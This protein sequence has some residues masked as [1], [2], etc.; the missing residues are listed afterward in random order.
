MTVDDELTALTNELFRR[1]GRNLLNF[2][3][4]EGMLKFLVANGQLQG[5]IKALT[6]L[7]NER[8]NSVLRS[9][10]GVL[11]GKFVNEILSDAGDVED[12]LAGSTEAWF[13]FKLSF[14]TEMQE[15]VELGDSLR[16][17]V[18]ERNDLVHHLDGRWD[19]KSIE[20]TRNL[21]AQLDEQ[22]ERLIPIYNQLKGMVLA[23]AE[24]MKQHADFLSSPEGSQL[25]EL[26]WLRHSP[27]VQLLTECAQRLAHAD[28]W[29]PLATAGHVLRQQVPEDAKSLKQCYGYSTL[30]QLVAATEMFDIWDEPTTR[31]FRT[32]YRIR[33]N[34]PEIPG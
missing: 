20:S 27:I 33:L 21:V 14:R 18:D 30:K 2:Q 8:A 10:M 22:R 9:T 7:R 11:A 23:V 1:I 24:G 4:I 17:L 3:K 34:E 6:D 29:L 15:S 16:S 19:N 28:G 5:P 31:G 12:S 13:S 25:I 32:V 26:L